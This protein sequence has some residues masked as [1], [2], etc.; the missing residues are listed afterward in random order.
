MR[1]RSR[2]QFSAGCGVVSGCSFPDKNSLMSL[3]SLEFFT[4]SL[5]AILIVRA[6][7]GPIR[8][9]GFTAVCLW[10]VS[11]YL[12]ATGLLSTL[13]LC[14]AG[15]GF[16]VGARRVARVGTIGIVLLTAA[17]IWMRRYSFLDV[18]LPESLLT[19][20]LATA[21][22][23]FLFFKIIHVIVDA[24]G[25]TI[26]DLRLMTYL[27]YCLNFTAYL[28]GPIQRYQHFERQW[29]RREEPLGPTFEAQLDAVNRVLRGLVKKFV[30]AEWLARYALL[31]GESVATMSLGH[32]VLVGIYAFYFFLY[33]DFS[34][35]CDIVI[36][37]GRLMGVRPPENFNLP[38]F[39]PNIAQFWLRVHRSLTLWL[40][41]YIFNPTYAAMLRG[42]SLVGRPLAAASLAI[43]LTMFVSGL[44]HGTAINFLLFGLLHGL[45]LVGFRFFEWLMIRRVGRKRLLVLRKRRVW[46]VFSTL[47][48]F[49]VTVAAYLLFVLDTTGIETLGQ[50]VWERILG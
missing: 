33:F 49:N 14:L 43:M 4:L 44:W 7:R 46:L 30:V 27:N 35:Y 28:L 38:F 12:N 9:F 23:S 5:L 20:I 39:S 19:D 47:L 37:I 36:G 10:F 26:G 29:N 18:L 31:P 21:G 34:G 16:A 45:Y 3:L 6:A 48:T 11:S 25:G 2:C 22:L 1:L 41:D 15:Y 8:V 13:L 42:R 50:R 40:T 32:G 17:F 24:Q